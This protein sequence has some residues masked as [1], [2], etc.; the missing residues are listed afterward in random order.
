MIGFWDENMPVR[1]DNP[2]TTASVY[3]GDKEIIV[4]VANWTDSLQTCR[5][6]IDWK[7]LGVEPEMVSTSIP[8]LQNF[9]PETAIDINEPLE[10]PAAK[11]YM[12]VLRKR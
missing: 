9:Q 10:L 3:K 8:A 7:K 4:A 5:F 2:N 12:I 11:G 1:T 6:R